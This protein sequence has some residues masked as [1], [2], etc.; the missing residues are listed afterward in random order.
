ME[1][2][3]HAHTERKK[4]THYF[5][6]F[7]MLFLAVFCGFL[8]ENQREHM[9]EH[10]R[11]KQY[12]HSLLNDLKKDTTNFNGVITSYTNSI[13]GMDTLIGLLKSPERNKYTGD[14]Y[15]FA[16]EVVFYKPFN[17]LDKT[18]EQMKSSGNLRLVHDTNLLDSL[19][20]YY[21]DFNYIE[22]HGPG[23]MELEVRHDL[24]ACY[25]KLF[26]ASVFQ[27]MISSPDSITIINRPVGNLPLLTNE[28]AVI[29]ELCMRVHNMSFVRRVGINQARRHIT[30]ATDLIK[31]IEEEY[32]L[33]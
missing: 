21:Y 2:H 18:Y 3:H 17:T 24:F 25:N 27:K 31:K 11:E 9:V 32:H 22:K 26:D 19:S 8:A 28:P 5:W 30:W 13:K 29:N 15:Y 16:K 1:V 6:E 14:I 23:Q 12:M 33:K 10:Q 4:W 20:N 7:L